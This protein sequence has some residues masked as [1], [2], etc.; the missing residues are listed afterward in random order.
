[1]FDIAKYL[2]K[3]KVISC[4]RDFLRNSLAEAIKN[5]CHIEIDPKKIDVKNYVARINERPIVK[6]E[7]FLKKE[8]ILKSLSEE[9]R[10]KV[11]DIV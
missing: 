10:E 11:K 8:K 5:I 3:F 4:S 6:S 9:V 7:I 2:E 1:M